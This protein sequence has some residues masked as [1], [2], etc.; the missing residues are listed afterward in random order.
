M[1]TI[2]QLNPICIDPCVLH[3]TVWGANCIVWLDK[4]RTP[5]YWSYWS[6]VVPPSQSSIARSLSTVIWG[7]GIGRCWSMEKERFRYRKCLGWFE[8]HFYFILLQT[9][10]KYTHR[11]VLGL[12]QTKV[13]WSRFR[14]PHLSFSISSHG[15]ILNVCLRGSHVVGSI[16]KRTASPH[17]NG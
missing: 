12:M 10:P 3:C 2:L 14:G 17:F 9:D 5:W 15:P 16:Q 4:V 11:K 7:K 6:G 1:D 13:V 8:L